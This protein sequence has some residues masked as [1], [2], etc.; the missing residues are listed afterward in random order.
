[1][2]LLVHC[3][4]KAFPSMRLLSPSVVS[5]LH[6]TLINAQASS[7]HQVPR[8]LRLLQFLSC[9]FSYPSAIS[10]LHVIPALFHF[11][12]FI[13]NW[14]SSCSDYC[15]I[16]VARFLSFV[17][18]PTLFVFPQSLMV[19]VLILFTNILFP[20]LYVRFNYALPPECQ[21]NCWTHDYPVFSVIFLKN[22]CKVS[23][24]FFSSY[25]GRII[26]A[27]WV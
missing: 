23:L 21:H 13:I 4:T 2:P 22:W 25:P 18:H 14:I 5:V 9:H 11:L 27:I 10:V 26:G 12:F 17:S 16:D 7:L 19:P 15:I 1:M 20:H 6:H 3:K 24:F 8:L